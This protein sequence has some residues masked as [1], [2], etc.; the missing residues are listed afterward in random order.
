MFYN[1]FRYYDCDTG[2]YLIADPVGLEGGINFYAYTPNPHSWIDP[3]GST[4]WQIDGDR[5]TAILQGRPFKEKYYKD[6]KTGLWW[7]KDTTGHGGSAYK[8]YTENSTSLEWIADADKDGQ[9]MPDKHKGDTGKNIAKKDCKSI[10]VK[11]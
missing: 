10:S 6:G 2:Q 7:S 3:L 9:F 1:R 8:I 11:K 4:G 5:P